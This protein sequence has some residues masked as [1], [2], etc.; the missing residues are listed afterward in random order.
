MTDDD[1]EEEEEKSDSL[2]P[3]API[4]VKSG[5]T[6]SSRYVY[7]SQFIIVPTKIRRI[8]V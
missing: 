7:K 4:G 5:G 8:L 3:G 6:A 2:C 1:E